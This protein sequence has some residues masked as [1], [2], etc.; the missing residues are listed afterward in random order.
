MPLPD[1][2]A[3]ARL[4]RHFRWG[5]FWESPERPP[6]ADT[7][8]AYIR[9]VTTLLQPLRNA[10]GPVIVTSGFRSVQ[11]NAAVGGAPQSRHVPTS[12]PG[13][14]AADIYSPTAAPHEL[15]RTLEQ[16]GAGGLG[17]YRAHVHVD[18]RRQRARW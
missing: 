9:L 4:S 10:H 5:E 15:A 16:L 12:E 18:T 6:P 7:W 2:P 13:V 11:R 3:S 8:P 14:V 1:R 17:V